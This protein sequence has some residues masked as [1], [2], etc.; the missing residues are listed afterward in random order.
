MWD[1]F[2]PYCT[3]FL[4]MCT[5]KQITNGNS[6]HCHRIWLG[7]LSRSVG[8]HCHWGVEWS[9]SW[10]CSLTLLFSVPSFPQGNRENYLNRKYSLNGQMLLRFAQLVLV[11]ISCFI[12]VRSSRNEGETFFLA[13]NFTEL[14]CSVKR[15]AREGEALPATGHCTQIACGCFR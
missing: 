11:L 7:C 6:V 10:I 4:M 13:C 15:W 9:A 14:L 5:G 3:V 2:S 12:L 1:G 8:S